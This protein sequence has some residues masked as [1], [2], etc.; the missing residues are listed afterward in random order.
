MKGCARRE[1]WLHKSRMKEGSLPA[2]RMGAVLASLFQP[3]SA[4]CCC[5]AG[6]FGSDIAPIGLETATGRPPGDRI[7]CHR[8]DEPALVRDRTDQSLAAVRVGITSQEPGC[9]RFRKRLIRLLL[10]HGLYG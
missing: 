8:S 2:L 9:K 6:C 3:I 10:P 5:W 1:G 4:C 7:E